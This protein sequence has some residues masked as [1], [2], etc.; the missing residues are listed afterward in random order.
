M[1]APCGAFSLGN[2]RLI[3]VRPK[4]RIARIRVYVLAS[5]R[6]NGPNGFSAK[7]LRDGYLAVVR[8]RL[9]AQTENFC[10]VPEKCGAYFAAH[11][12]AV[13][14]LFASAPIKSGTKQKFPKTLVSRR[15][16]R[17]IAHTITRVVGPGK[18]SAL[19]YSLRRRCFSLSQLQRYGEEE[20]SG[21]G[22]QAQ[23]HTHPWSRRAR[24]PKTRRRAPGWREG[25]TQRRERKTARG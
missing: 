10:F 21:V 15:R 13:F 7:S 1:I 9:P 3:P 12:R 4:G 20:N 5:D 19:G 23:G 14:V 22:R 2:L 18:P 6:K 17:I 11:L 16:Q 25:R 8:R 24:P